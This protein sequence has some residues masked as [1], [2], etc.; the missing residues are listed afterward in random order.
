MVII[1]LIAAGAVL[2]IGG[3]IYVIKSTIDDINFI[4][5]NNDDDIEYFG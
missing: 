1:G 4:F 3:I 5:D 2:V